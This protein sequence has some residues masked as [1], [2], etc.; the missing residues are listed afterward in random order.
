VSETPAGWY[1]DD[2]DPQ[3]ARW[4]D[5]SAWTQDT[6]AIGDVPEGAPAPTR[7]PRPEPVADPWALDDDRSDDTSDIGLTADLSALPIAHERL[8]QPDPYRQQW[9][10]GEEQHH[11]PT[12]GD[13]VRDWPAWT[14]VA[15]PIALVAL[16]VLA[17]AA[18]SSI[19]S[20]SQN[21]TVDTTVSTTTTI[22]STTSEVT[23]LPPPVTDTSALDTT[24]SVIDTTSSSTRQRTTPTTRRRATTTTVKIPSNTAPSTT[25]AP[26]TTTTVAA[27][28]ST[29]PP[30]TT[31]TTEAPTTTQCVP[32]TFP[33]NASC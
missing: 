30:E 11:P 14:R 6:V 29:A 16:M 13:R 27:T 19:S 12:F 28:T 2:D 4:W 10:D 26:G 23:F 31:T 18:A 1:R 15:A 9:Y 7:F 24:T 3:L 25:A 5:G 20:K 22:P 17:V 33:P 21:D 8:F 32:P